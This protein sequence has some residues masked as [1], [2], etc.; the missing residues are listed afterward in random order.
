MPTKQRVNFKVASVTTF[1]VGSYTYTAHPVTMVKTF[2]ER[3]RRSE[4]AWLICDSTGAEMMVVTKEDVDDTFFAW[5][6][7]GSGKCFCVTVADRCPTAVSAVEVGHRS[8]LVLAR[9][10]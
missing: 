4:N 3:A 10:E 8:S 6:V 7:S 5:A 1:T 9:I 2:F